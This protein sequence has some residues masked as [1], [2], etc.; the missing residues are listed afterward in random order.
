MEGDRLEPVAEPPVEV[1][2]GQRVAARAG[3]GKAMIVL[4]GRTRRHR[5]DGREGGN[6]NGRAE[7]L[8]GGHRRGQQR[9]VRGGGRLGIGMLGGE[10]LDGRAASG[11]SRFQWM[12]GALA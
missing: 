8:F 12:T 7:H 4:A 1:L 10:R 2:K 11:V 6:S 9:K 5:S 3:S